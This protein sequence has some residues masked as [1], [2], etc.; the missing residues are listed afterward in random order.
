MCN[1]KDYVFVIGH[2]RNSTRPNRQIVPFMWSAI[3]CR[4]I[5]EQDWTIVTPSSRTTD[6]ISTCNGCGKNHN[7]I[8]KSCSLHLLS[9]NQIQSSKAFSFSMADEKKKKQ[10]WLI[11]SKLILIIRLVFTEHP[12]YA[13]GPFSLSTNVVIHVR[14]TL[15]EK[16]IRTIS[17]NLILLME[18]WFGN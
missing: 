1:K 6:A 2:L 15:G 14:L 3:V 17:S 18:N 8:Q 9:F 4:S 7:C 13:I 12:A 11:N 16:L 10:T 5:A